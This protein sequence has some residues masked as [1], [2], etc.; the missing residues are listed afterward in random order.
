MGEATLYHSGSQLVSIPATIGGKRETKGNAT[1]NG[2]ESEPFCLCKT[3][4]ETETSKGNETSLYPLLRFRESTPLNPK[5]T[6][7]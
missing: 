3:G 7:Q 1:G 5:N 4:N 6:H 2:M